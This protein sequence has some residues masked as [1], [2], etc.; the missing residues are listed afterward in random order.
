MYFTGEIFKN[1]GLSDSATLGVGAFKL[2]ATLG[3]VVTVDRFGR[4]RLLLVGISLMLL[5]L[6]LLTGCF[7]Y[8][9]EGEKGNDVVLDAFLI[10]GFFIY[11]AGY[12]V[13]LS[14]WYFFLPRIIV[15]ERT[16]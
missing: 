4:R 7:H 9:D 14:L 16:G 5:A 6:C 2:L 12:Q 13:S 15:R 8:Y 3:A 1:F 10:M 11:I